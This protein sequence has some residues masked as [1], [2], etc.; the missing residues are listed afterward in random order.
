MAKLTLLEMTQSI[1]SAMDSDSVSSIDDTV[2]SVQ[3]ADTIREVY[4]EMMSSRDW[5]FLMTLSSLEGLGNV[6]YPTKMRIPEGV[7]KLFWVKYDKT[8]VEYLPPKLFIDMLDQRSGTDID[9]NGYCLSRNPLYWT[10]VDDNYVLFDSINQSVDTTLV[11]SK[12][13]CYCVRVPTW[14]HVDTFVPDIPEKVFPTLLAEA[15]ATCFLNIKQQANNKEEYK[16]RKGRVRLQNEAWRVNDGEYKYNTNVN[17][18][19]K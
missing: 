18:G 6:S 10:S 8:D 11:S 15:K 12:C 1:L 7:N 9:S 17:Y 4:E 3:V 13:Q 19:R 16:A 14:T 5:P 2:E